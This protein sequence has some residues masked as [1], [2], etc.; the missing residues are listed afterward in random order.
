MG[1]D[2]A[3]LEVHAADG[4]RPLH[5]FPFPDTDLRTDARGGTVD[6]RVRLTVTVMRAVAREIGPERVG[7]RIAPGATPTAST[8]ARRRPRSAVRHRRHSPNSA[9]RPPT[10]PCAP[11]PAHGPHR[12]PPDPVRRAARTVAGDIHR[13]PAAHPRGPRPGRGRG[14]GPGR[15]AG[16]AGADPISS[17]RGF[18]ADLD[19]VGRLR[20][21]EA[22][23]NP[24]RP[25]LP[26]CTR[27]AE[28]C[29]D[30]PD[31][32][33]RIPEPENCPSPVPRRREP[34]PARDRTS[35]V[36]GQG[37]GVRGRTRAAAGRARSTPPGPPPAPSCRSPRRRRR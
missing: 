26:L 13:E 5:R 35:Q 37:S 14:P 16:P 21:R 11:L 10:P 29:T 28:G 19:R 30:H 31:R 36:R 25:E 4:R 9:T 2:F 12:R 3:G 18:P 34:S 27:G 23:L 22:P 24:I 8:R 20:A 1:T 33:G 17:A 32:P 6:N 15:E 7:A